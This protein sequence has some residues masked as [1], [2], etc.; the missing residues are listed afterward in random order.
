RHAL[1]AALDLPPGKQTPEPLPVATEVFLPYGSIFSANM[2]PYRSTRKLLC[3]LIELLSALT[4]SRPTSR[5]PLSSSRGRAWPCLSRRRPSS[6][7]RSTRSNGGW[8]GCWP[9]RQLGHLD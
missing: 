4:R 3:F 7:R 9:T 8:S 5:R 6:S 1:T 2:S